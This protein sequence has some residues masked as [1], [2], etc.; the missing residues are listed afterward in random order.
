MFW[1]Q[2]QWLYSW[3]WKKICYP[4]HEEGDSDSDIDTYCEYEIN[5]FHCL[6]EARPCNKCYDDDTLLTYENG[7]K[8]CISDEKV[9]EN[10]ITANVTTSYI[11]NLYN[12]TS[13][14]INNILYYSKFHERYMCYNIFEKVIKSKNIYLDEFNNEENIPIEENSV[15][16]K[17]ILHLMERNVINV[18]MK[19]SE[20]PD[21][22]VIAH[23]L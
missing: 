13:C 17:I 8:T 4:K 10:C 22:K 3:F 18:I 11:K 16:K 7:I 9:L 12:C 21:V 20:C 1:M 14:K 15:C 23:F 5:R 6:I 19:M 2:L